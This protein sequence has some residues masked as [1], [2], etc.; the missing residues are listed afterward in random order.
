MTLRHSTRHVHMTVAKIIKDNLASLGWTDPARTPFGATALEFTTSLPPAYGEAAKLDPGTVA[1]T[2]ER[3]FPVEPEEMGPLASFE[4][5]IFIDV[6]MEN[7]SH[8]IAVALDVRDILCGRFPGT[9]TL[10]PVLDFTQV[11]PVAASGWQIDLM[12]FERERDAQRES[13]Q[14]CRV[15][16]KVY[17]QDLPYTPV[18]NP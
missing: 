4:V 6:F 14:K 16:A 12:D 2:T 10:V 13:W 3:E 1:I 15:I 18:V 17:F 11:P 7:E 9:A 8:A 5:P